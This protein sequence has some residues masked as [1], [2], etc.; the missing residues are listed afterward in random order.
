MTGVENL[1]LIKMIHSLIKRKY[2]PT[3]AYI[4]LLTFLAF[5]SFGQS[6][7]LGFYRDDWSIW[8]SQSYFWRALIGHNHPGTWIED[9]FLFKIFGFNTYLWQGLGIVLR[10]VAAF[11]VYLLMLG[12]TKSKRQALVA[13]VLFAP[14]FIA[15]ESVTWLSVYIV[16]QVVICTC[17]AFYFWIRFIES[18]RWQFAIFTYLLLIVSIIGDPG[19]SIFILPLISLWD[20]LN[21]F[22]TKKREK[23]RIVLIR[24][25][26]FVVCILFS[27]KIALGYFYTSN[28]SFV[29]N[30]KGVLDN[31]N[32]FQSVFKST[33]NMLVSWIQSVQ[34]GS[35]QQLPFIILSVFA[36]AGLY[37]TLIKKS[38]AGAALLLFTIWMPF[39]YIPNTIL[40]RSFVSP[41]FHRYLGLSAVGYACFVTL[42]FSFF[43]S[44]I[45]FY[46]IVIIFIVLNIKASNEITNWEV[47]F[48]AVSFTEPLWN[49]IYSDVPKGEKDSIFM[50]LGKDYAKDVVL[51]WSGSIPYGIRANITD[52][53]AMPIATA[54]TAL[55]IKLLCED[56]TSRP[57]MFVWYKQPHRI[58][59]SHVHAWELNNNI[60]TNVSSRERERLI[61]EA[62]KIGCTPL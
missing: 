56:G 29:D 34:G 16:P 53:D 59:L 6:L 47:G 52:V 61:V 26:L 32:F 18:S 33:G 54:D 57:S 2:F 35:S 39:V 24:E 38:R 51:A 15:Q 14:L 31:P 4:C 41:P 9:F 30:I 5:A 27:G 21:W 60:L 7:K 25:I 20:F 37:L 55:I 36:A 28:I 1:D 11:C 17:L 45:I 8:I 48:R 12:V 49:Q 13:G 22:V 58:L 44:K 46:G 43:K 10:I 40:D 42:L 19:R 23:F 50:Y 62:K 3:F